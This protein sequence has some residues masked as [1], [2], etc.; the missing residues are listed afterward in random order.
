[1]NESNEINLS[2]VCGWQRFCQ[3]MVLM[4]FIWQYFDVNVETVGIRKSLSSNHVSSNDQALFDWKT[5][6]LVSKINGY[7]FFLVAHSLQGY[8]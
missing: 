8:A 3:Q 2:Y 6:M 7:E 1:M 5:G 4:D